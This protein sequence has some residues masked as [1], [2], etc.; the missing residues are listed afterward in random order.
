M[1]LPFHSPQTSHRTRPW[2]TSSVSGGG[3]RR[4]TVH[5]EAKRRRMRPEGCSSG[6]VY[7]LLTKIPIA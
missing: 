1:P 7:G 5:G 4:P 2:G 6:G 3:V